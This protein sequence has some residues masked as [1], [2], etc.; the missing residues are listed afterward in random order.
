MKKKIGNVVQ[1]FGK[2]WSVIVFICAI[3]LL[4]L[5]FVPPMFDCEPIWCMSNSMAPAFH[6]GALCYID[7]NYDPET[8]EVGDIIAYTLSNGTM[9]THRVHNITEEGIITKGDANAT[10][11]FAPI[12]KEQIIGENVVQIE[13]L[14]NFFKD[15]PNQLLISCVVFAIAL[16]LMFDVLTSVLLEEESDDKYAKKDDENKVDMHCVSASDISTGESDCEST[17]AC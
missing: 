3:A 8:V 5:R 9:V 7:K 16:M 12:S 4:G 14:G 10:E 13:Y 11:D 1:V 15:F 17:D 2:I 6:E